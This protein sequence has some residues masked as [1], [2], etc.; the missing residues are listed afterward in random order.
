M[1][2][3]IGYHKTATTWLQRQL[4]IPEF[5]FHPVWDHYGVE[6]HI[7]GPH[8]L[9]FDMT[10][11]RNALELQSKN[12]P[13]HLSP[14][15]S[16]EILSGLPYNG[17]RE[18]ADYARRLRTIAPTAKILIT[19][20][21]QKRLLVSLYMQ[22]VRRGGTTKP[23]NFFSPQPE[24]GYS[25]FDYRHLCFD[26]LVGYY[27]QLFGAAQVLVLPHELLVRQPH[28]FI[29]KIY[30]FAGVPHAVGR[31]PDS[32]RKEGA[33][34]QEFILCLTRPLNHFRRDSAG[35]VPVLD[36]SSCTRL[37]QRILGALSRSTAATPLR[38]HRPITAFV[39]R[40]FSGK[41]AASNRQLLTL[42]P[43]LE[44]NNYEQ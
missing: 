3:H 39:Q 1:L 25:R 11:T 15:I 36:G 24:L 28:A 35:G 16:S 17:A 32:A 8:E 20:R 38:C 5:G 41:F 4:F 14:C 26:R 43:S 9:D 30:Q 44:L 33:S 12:C 18:A 22:Y 31:Y 29:E 40:E 7:T 34:D 21:E 13:D 6:A 2:I 23:H 10:E 19:I 27:Q 42:A 37:A